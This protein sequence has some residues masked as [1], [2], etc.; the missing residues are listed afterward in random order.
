MLSLFLMNGAPALYP[1]GI[2]SNN[3]ADSSRNSN[4]N[5]MLKKK[6]AC[7]ID[8]RVKVSKPYYHS[9]FQQFCKAKFLVFR[10]DL[11]CSCFSPVFYFPLTPLGTKPA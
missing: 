2:T 9:K 4:T 11:I 10:C 6:E 3:K 1:A 7:N 5:F 8:S